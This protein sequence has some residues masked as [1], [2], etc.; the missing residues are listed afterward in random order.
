MKSEKVLPP[1]A[2]GPP[3][4]GAWPPSSLFSKLAPQKLAPALIFNVGPTRKLAPKAP[5]NFFR[6]FSNHGK[7]FRTF[8]LRNMVLETLKYTTTLAPKAPKKIFTLFGAEGAENFFGHFP[9]GA[10]GPHRPYFQSW[11]PKSWPLALF[12]FLARAKRPGGGGTV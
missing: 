8:F 2:L 5:E 4:P 3:P 7:K 6:A 12:R 11:P 10:L 1:R 9:M